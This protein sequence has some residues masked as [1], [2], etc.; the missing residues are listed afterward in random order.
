MNQLSQRATIQSP[1]AA[2]ATPSLRSLSGMQACHD[3][4]EIHAEQLLLVADDD[5]TARVTAYSVM[6]AFVASIKG[7]L[8]DLGTLST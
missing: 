5:V 6:K 1:A 2:A 3:R 8:P 7:T 4:P